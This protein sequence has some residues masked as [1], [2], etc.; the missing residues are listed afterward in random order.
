MIERPV[1]PMLVV[2][3]ET[4]WYAHET[5]FRYV[6]QAGEGISVSPTLPIG[7][8]FFVPREEVTFRDCTAVGDRGDRG[9]AA[10]VQRAQGGRQPADALRPDLQPALP[11]AGRAQRAEGD[12][13]KTR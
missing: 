3:V 5:E 12:E 7:Q 6:L 8:V 10:D 2:R 11:P 4:D 9:V 1:A 13:G